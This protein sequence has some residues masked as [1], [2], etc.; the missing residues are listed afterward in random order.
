MAILKDIEVR[1][2][3]NI[4][5]NVYA[6]HAGDALQEYE[7]PTA[8]YN[9]SSDFVEKYV[10]AVTGQAFQ[11]E[12]YLRAGFKFYAAQGILFYLMIDDDTVSFCQYYT[13]LEVEERQA[14][15]EPFIISSYPC[16]KGTR[17]FRMIFTFGSLTLGTYRRRCCFQALL[18]FNR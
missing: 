5:G 4:S 17:Y 13:R 14:S 2:A 12:V 10:E 6:E 18:S 8:T 15:G 1:I 7:R 3:R 9:E 16:S 11:I